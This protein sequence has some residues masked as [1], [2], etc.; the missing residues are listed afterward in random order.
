MWSHDYEKKI[1][2]HFLANKFVRIWAQLGLLKDSLEFRLIG[3]FSV[4]LFLNYHH[5]STHISCPYHIHRNKYRLVLI[6]QIYNLSFIQ[7]YINLIVISFINLM[8]FV[9]PNYLIIDILFHVIRL[10]VL[11]II[12]VKING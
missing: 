4:D 1:K 12:M 9:Q 7:H 2:K 5:N 6:F 3:N 10:I 11:M 8:D